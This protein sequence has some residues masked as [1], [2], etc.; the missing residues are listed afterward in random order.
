MSPNRVQDYYHSWTLRE[1]ISRALLY[2]MCFQPF[3]HSINTYRA[4]T[5]CRVLCYDTEDKNHKQ[6]RND[7]SVLMEDT[8]DI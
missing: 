8:K 1:M 4:P 2:I 6:N 7:L 3:I 5:V